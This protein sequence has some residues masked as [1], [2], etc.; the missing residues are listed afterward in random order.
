MSSSRKKDHI[1]M[2]FASVPKGQMDLLGL[3]Y[4]PVLSAHPENHDAIAMSFLGYEFGMPLWIS[5]MTGGTEKAF[6]IN[7]NLAKA[8][9]EFKIGMG[10]GSC[11][12]LL[13]S[14]ERLK[15]FDVKS[16]MPDMPLYA[17]L[18]IAQLEELMDA[19]ALPKV[20]E[21]IK[22]LSADGLVIH[23]NPMQEWAQEEGDRYKRPALKTI[24][25]ICDEIK[26]SLIVK[27][28]GQG[29]GPRSL[30]SLLELPISAIELAAFGGTNFSILERQRRGEE[31][32]QPAE[33]FNYVGHTAFEMIEM[34][35][36]MKNVSSEVE[37]IISGG[38]K[39]VVMGH[40]LRHHLKNRNSVLGMA[41]T[42]LRHAM[43]P[44]EELQSYLNDVQECFSMAQAFL[45]PHEDAAPAIG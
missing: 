38:V 9:G 43:G 24:R 11:R 10:L 13:D 16:F 20:S 3:S 6:Q 15:D 1:E 26:T 19:N 28:V 27:E 42:I 25:T 5:S 40:A 29:M 36:E 23:V 32:A 30:R 33:S 31:G 4:E 18:G 45:V 21:L 12:P 34:L 17:N 44:Y 22:R 14:D 35:N 7:Q 8:C 39:D 37:I 41:S 2:S